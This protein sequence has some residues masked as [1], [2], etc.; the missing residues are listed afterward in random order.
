MKRYILF[1]VFIIPLSICYSQALEELVSKDFEEETLSYILAT[2]SKQHTIDIRVNETLLPSKRFTYSFKKMPMRNVLS[3]LL[4]HNNLHYKEYA[5]D[6]IIVVPIEMINVDSVSTLLIKQVDSSDISIGMITLGQPS[7]LDNKT[8]VTILAT[9]VDA[10]SFGAISSALVINQTTGEYLTTGLDGSFRLDL[11]PGEYLIQINSISHESYSTKITIQS[12]DIWEVLMDPKSYLIDEIVISGSNAQRKATETTIG[13]EQLSST[14][15]KQLGIF[16]GEADIVKSLLSLAGVSNSGDGASGFNVRGGSI[17]QNLILQDGAVIYN[18]SHV[19]GFF[20]TFNPDI[21]QSTSLNKGHIP[22]HYGGRVS[23]VLD[24]NIKDASNEALS[25][26]GGIGLISS[27]VSLEVPIIKSKSS[28]LLSGRL[29]YA[30]W[31]LTQVGDP[32]VENSDADFNDFNVKYSHNFSSKTKASISYFQ[33][34]DQFSFSDKFGYNWKNKILQAE[35]RHLFSDKIS[36]FLRGAAGSLSNSQFLPEGQLAFN[37]T[38][39]IKYKQLSSGLLWS[40]DQHV[41]RL[42]VEYINNNVQPEEL[43][44]RNNS[45]VRPDFAEKQKGHEY[46]FYFNDRFDLSDRLSFDFGLRYSLYQQRGPY[47]LNIYSSLDDIS[48]DQIINNTFFEAG[49]VIRYGGFEPRLAMRFNITEDI[50]FKTSY[51]KARQYIQLLSNTVTP[52]P[53]DIWQ[54]STPYIKPLISDNFSAGVAHSFTGW[55]YNLDFYYKSQQNTIDYRDFASL[56]LESNLE[57]QTLNG[58]GRSY[59][60]EFTLEKKADDLSGRLSYVYS[61][62]ERKTLANQPQSINA[63]DWY[64][65][66]FDQPHNFKIFLNYQISKRDRLNFSFVYNTG[67][68]ITAP[69]GTYLIDNVVISNFSERNAFRLPA[70]HRLDIS[71]TLS[72]NRRKSARYKSDLTVS[73]YNFYARKNAFSIFY[74]QERGSVDAFRLAVIGSV[75]PS[76]SYN[77]QF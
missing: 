58:I 47:E 10:R 33:S 24:I 31:V 19:L 11:I 21:I 17:D 49:E 40:P 16:M 44:P 15:I 29:S 27:K 18:P 48:L 65:S 72:I 41:F 32:H 75:I 36:L 56:L 60:I 52:T 45:D 63:G 1:W 8:K 2:I 62:S 35:V 46:A 37:L 68:P 26:K 69:V 28:L 38:S 61:R 12:A 71:Y 74:R 39:G 3:I 22:A 7:K 55:Q 51:N 66:S 64:P 9:L 6:K 67:R 25:V 20:S 54:V 43:L 53:V 77:F 57:T 42:G 13:L 59:G 76:I 70:Y 34:F 50:A 73:F 23:S 14:E 5:K 30:K 4:N